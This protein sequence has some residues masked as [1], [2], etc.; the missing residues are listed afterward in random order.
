MNNPYDYEDYSNESELS[1]YDKQYYG[2]F[3]SCLDIITNKKYKRD[4]IYFDPKDDRGA[5][6]VGDQSEQSN[7]NLPDEVFYS[8]G[9]DKLPNVDWKNL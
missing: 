4:L 3:K 2:L 1:E 6:W 5:N 7:S 8:A 9:K